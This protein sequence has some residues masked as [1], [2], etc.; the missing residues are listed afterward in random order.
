MCDYQRALATSVCVGFGCGAECDTLAGTCYIHTL[1]SH[2]CVY[3]CVCV[4]MNVCTGASTGTD[5][6]KSPGA[7]SLVP[8]KDDGKKKLQQFMHNAR[9]VKPPPLSPGPC[10]NTLIALKPP[11]HNACC[12]T[13]VTCKHV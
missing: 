12:P 2:W 7:T 9:K 11:F 10:P 6:P 1:A 13:F 5:S 4:S 3:V 8:K